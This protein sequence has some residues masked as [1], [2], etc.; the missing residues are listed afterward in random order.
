MTYFT[1]VAV[2]AVILFVAYSFGRFA[3]LPAPPTFNP[4]KQEIE[5][6]GTGF[7]FFVIFVALVI[8]FL[9][10]NSGPESNIF[11]VVAGFLL[12]STGFIQRLKEL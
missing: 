6:I 8:L 10:I 1:T 3:S 9:G 11:I 5:P 2:N 7:M 12:F 4:Q